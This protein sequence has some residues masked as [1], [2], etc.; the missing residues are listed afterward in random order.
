VKKVLIICLHRP[1]RSPN[2]RY[3]Y[4]QYLPFLEKNGY[5]FDVSNLLNEK[6][7][8]VFYLYGNYFWKFMIYLKMW[9]I[10][11]R[12]WRRMNHYDIIFICRDALITSSLFF[13]KRFSRSKA[14]LIYDFDDAI[15][16]QNVSEGNKRLAFLKNP[17]KTGKIIGLCD[18]TF[19]GNQFL[20]DYA[21]QFANKVE[22]IPSTIDMN[23][24]ERTGKKINAGK[25]CIGW[26][27]SP[28]TLRHFKLII[29]A[30]KKIKEKFGERV[31]FKIIG[32]EN[33]YCAELN[34]KGERW[35]ALTEAEDLSL[36]DIG[37]MPLP[38][39]KWEKGKCG[40]KGLQYMGLGIPAVMSPVGANLEI[41]QDGINGYLPRSEEEWVDRLSK[42]IENKELRE[43]I[44]NAGRQTVI[45]K[46]SVERWKQKYLDSFNTLTASN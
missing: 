31:E 39:E 10:R 29:P 25:V 14:K 8:K 18:L 12:D 15:W 37:I 30:L 34:V 16:M 42:L 9:T 32:D 17:A 24:Y 45:G 20:A 27:G 4:E 35:A 26:T 1:N 40:M 5:R 41:I 7:D 38:D 23:V 33:Y 43:T 46:Y 3:R 13:E 22:I 11:I 6:D 19:A 21:L 2:Q 28:T 36:I 44:G